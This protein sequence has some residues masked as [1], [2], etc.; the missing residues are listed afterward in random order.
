MDEKIFKY[1]NA[2]IR[3]KIPLAVQGNS[4]PSMP[5]KKIYIAIIQKVERNSISANIMADS[6]FKTG[7]KINQSPENLGNVTV[8]MKGVNSPADIL[9]RMV[10]KADRRFM[11]FFPEPEKNDDEEINELDKALSE[12]NNRDVHPNIPKK[13]SIERVVNF[14]KEE[15]NLLIPSFFV[16][17]GGIIRGRW[18]HGASY[19]FWLNFPSEGG[20][21]WTL[22][23]PRISDHGLV[24]V[25]GKCG[26]D[27]D[28]VTVAEK[29]GVAMRK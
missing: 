22:S 24:R 25:S 1:F 10:R 21:G 19:T 7:T 5:W 2:R 28:V 14:F 12:L 15:D 17:E 23:F 3:K 13:A 26:E 27:K 29:F 16:S 6:Y 8:S 9:G 11:S 18:Q 20:L 4:R